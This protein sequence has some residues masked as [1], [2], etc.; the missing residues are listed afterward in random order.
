M[1]VDRIANE[2]GSDMLVRVQQILKTMRDLII[3]QARQGIAR[4][5]RGHFVP[6]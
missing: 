6:R 1:L 5:L 2:F 4:P 3:G